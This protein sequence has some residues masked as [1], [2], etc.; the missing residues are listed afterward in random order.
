MSLSWEEAVCRR[1][2]PIGTPLSS[3]G[4]EGRALTSA[5]GIPLDGWTLPDSYSQVESP[6]WSTPGSVFRP[7][8]VGPVLA[9][10]PSAGTVPARPH[11]TLSDN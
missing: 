11:W 3:A 8:P 9:W 4:S 10:K 5:A 6:A 7:D 1:L 2:S